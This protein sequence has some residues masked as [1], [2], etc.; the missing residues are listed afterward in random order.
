MKTIIIATIFL[1]SFISTFAGISDVPKTKN[2]DS[3]SNIKIESYRFLPYA[4][5]DMVKM[6][7]VFTKGDYTLW[8]CQADVV[9]TYPADNITG[10]TF[11]Y[12]VYKNNKFHLTVNEFN[13]QNVFK[14][15]TK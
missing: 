2:Y 3:E 9:T 8:K 6:Q 11:N 13:K 12:F 15:F 10:K 4:K 5:T 7:K 14:F 1:F